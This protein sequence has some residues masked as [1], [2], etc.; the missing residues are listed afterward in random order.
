MYDLL[1]FLDSNILLQQNSKLGKF[2]KAINSHF[3]DNIQNKKDVLTK[4]KYMHSEDWNIVLG[5]FMDFFDTFN[6]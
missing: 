4:L 1:L 6:D 2:E 5:V 3:K